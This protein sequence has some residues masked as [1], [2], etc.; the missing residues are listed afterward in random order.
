TVTGCMYGTLPPVSPPPGD[1]A[2]MYGAPPSV[3]EVEDEADSSVN[4]VLQDNNELTDVDGSD[5]N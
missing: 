5:A 3:E 2:C 4:S 1:P